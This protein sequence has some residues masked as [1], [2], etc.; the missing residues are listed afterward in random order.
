MKK[1]LKKFWQG[2]VDLDFAYVLATLGVISVP[3]SSL[4]SFIIW[5]N[6]FGT[7]SI[8]EGTFFPFKYDNLDYEW[9]FW[10]NFVLA[11]IFLFLTEK[12]PCDGKFVHSGFLTIVV[13]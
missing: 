7:A 3:F 2:D 12:I 1:L 8:T 13:L 5:L 10:I 6:I 11:S 4:I 9:L